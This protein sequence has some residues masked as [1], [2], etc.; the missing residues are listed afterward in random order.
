V[1]GY[2]STRW[3]LEYV[4]TPTDP[5]LALDVRWLERMGALA[6]GAVFRPRW[7]CRGEPSGWIVTIRDPLHESLILDYKIRAPGKDWEPVREAIGLGTTTCHYGGERTWFLCPGC[8]SRR[9]VLFAL[10]GRFRC[11]AC[12]GLAYS[13]TRE[14]A[15]DRSH[16][17][18]VVLMSKLGGGHAH[19]VRTIPP[20][21]RGMH[22][23]TYL[24]LVKQ[25]AR[26]LNGS[27]A[28]PDAL[29]AKP[30]NTAP[31]LKFAGSNGRE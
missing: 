24:H 29:V 10:G 31:S 26:E 11:R 14:D 13:S 22:H 6:P 5:L 16:R 19:P 21:P 1:G 15:A 27:D 4:R 28:L 20:R 3:N 2:F 23:R 17:R 8:R 9:A 7:T 25:M 18:L 30:E 12:H